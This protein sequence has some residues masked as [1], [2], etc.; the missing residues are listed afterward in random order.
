MLVEIENGE[1]KS[2]RA[3]KFYFDTSIWLDFF[4]N[5]DEPNLPKAKLQKN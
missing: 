4:E 1:V 3:K 2:E 5:R